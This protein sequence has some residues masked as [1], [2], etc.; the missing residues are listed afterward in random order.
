MVGV[1][2]QRNLDLVPNGGAINHLNEPQADAPD[3]SLFAYVFQ[4]L[5]GFRIGDMHANLKLIIGT[6]ET[7]KRDSDRSLKC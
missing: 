4:I 6:F 3:A 1:A 2:V 5:T 7:R